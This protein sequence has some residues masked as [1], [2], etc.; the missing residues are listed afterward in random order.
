MSD[1]FEVEVEKKF[2]TEIKFE[3]DTDINIDFDKDVDIDVDIKVDAE[4]DG[5]VAI[6]IFDAEALGKDSYVEVNSTVLVIQDTLSHVS[7]SIVAAA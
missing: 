4:I 2:D 1:T 5:N 7:G 3:S 6:F